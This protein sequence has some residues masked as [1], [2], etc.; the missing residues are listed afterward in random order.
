MSNGTCATHCLFLALK[1]KSSDRA[2]ERYQGFVDGCNHFSIPKPALL[3]IDEDSDALTGLLKEFLIQNPKLTGIF[4]SNDFL[5]LETIRCA[6]DLGLTVPGDLSIIG[7]DGIKVGTMVEPTLATIV[8]DPKVM[9]SGAARSVLAIIQ[10][11]EPPVQPDPELTF[12]FRAGGS[13]AFPAAERKDGERAA[14][15]SPSNNLTKKNFKN[16]QERSI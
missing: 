14:T 10:G 9:G 13:L 5:A 6:R 15:L 7:F 16:Q 1:F 2:R 8:T 12:S 11:V 4:V 3:E